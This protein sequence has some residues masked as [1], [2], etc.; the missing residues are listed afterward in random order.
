MDQA[1]EV[2][3]KRLHFMPYVP[4]CF[5]SALHVWGVEALMQTTLALWRE[6][7]RHVPTN[8]L[9]YMLAGAL[10]SH[11]PPPGKRQQRLRIDRLRQVGVNPPT[12]IFSVNNPELVHFSYQRYLENQIR[13]TFGFDHTHLKLVFQRQR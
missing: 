13:T 5:T 10:A 7:L 12:F 3:R 4:I 8:Q 2:V 6:R 11:A 1:A 9:Q